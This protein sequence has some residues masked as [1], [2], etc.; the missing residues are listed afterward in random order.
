MKG[1]VGLTHVRTVGLGVLLGA[2]A[3]HGCRDRGPA[4]LVD[5]A[6]AGLADTA[7]LTARA[8][9]ALGAKL[10]DRYTV[11]RAGWQGRQ[12]TVRFAGPRRERTTEVTEGF[13]VYL[14]PGAAMTVY[15]M[16]QL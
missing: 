2:A 9:V 1:S 8:R 4:S 6:A 10:A 15:E 14:G 13:I 3:V 12:Y 11:V 7:A 5:S 16:P